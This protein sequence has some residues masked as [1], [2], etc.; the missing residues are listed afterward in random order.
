MSNPGLKVIMKE[1]LLFVARKMRSEPTATE[2][3]LWH[4]LRNFQLG[5]FKFRRQQIIER[6]IV[7][8]Y[9][10]KAKLAV[11]VDGEIHKKQKL[12]DAERDAYLRDLGIRV[13]RFTNKQVMTELPSVLNRIQTLCAESRTDK[14]EVSPFPSKGKGKGMGS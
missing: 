14:I 12:L 7:D 1:K 5:G 3:R 13:E 8:F 9:C 4:H 11:E 6:F 2:K 10:P